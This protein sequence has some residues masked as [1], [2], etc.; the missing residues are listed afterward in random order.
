MCKCLHYIGHAFMLDFPHL[1]I[2][3][4]IG[5]NTLAHHVF[6][7]S[8][9]SKPFLVSN[10]LHLIRDLNRA[11]EGEVFPRRIG[12]FTSRLHRTFIILR[13]VLIRFLILVL[14][15]DD[16]TAQDIAQQ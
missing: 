6:H 8:T 16:S 3:G 14:R 13:C 15:S 1:T 7:Q 10:G 5:S 11:D 9:N 12:R 4:F 2:L